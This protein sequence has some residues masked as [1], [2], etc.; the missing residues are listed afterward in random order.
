MIVKWDFVKRLHLDPKY[1]LLNARTVNMLLELFKMLDWR[2]SGSLDDVQ[3]QCI[4]THATDLKESQIYKIFD[5]FDLD[6]SGSVEFDEFYL[7]I[8][9]LVAMKDGTAKNFMFQNWR[10]CFEILDADGSGDVSRKEFQTLGFLFNFT[11]AAIRRI[12]QEFDVTGN[13]ELDNEDFQ[14]FVLAAIELQADM[15]RKGQT[16]NQT[17]NPLALGVRKLMNGLLSMFGSG[18][19]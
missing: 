6:G 19:E 9:I 8:C 7:L 3:F 2:G 18:S 17:F 14:L 11:P 15:D 12:Y 1:G 16:N 13:S 10:S 4:M 5:L